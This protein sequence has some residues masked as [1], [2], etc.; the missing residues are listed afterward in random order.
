MLVVGITGGVATGKSL[1]AGEFARLGA[2]VVDADALA[3][4]VLEPDLPAWREVVAEFGRHILAPDG[5]IDR[6]K[7]G[8]IVFA[9]PEK[10]SRLEQ[11][12]HPRVLAEQVRRLAELKIQ[13]AQPLVVLDVP[14]LIEVGWHKLVDRVALVMADYQCQVKRLQR[15][16]GLSEERAKLRI[17]A[18]LPLLEKQKHAHYIIYNNGSVEEALSQAKSVYNQLAPCGRG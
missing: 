8:D 15:R 5:T 16:N 10:R 4:K 3:R 2:R 18:Q 1:V 13:G 14:L 17:E 7:L 6:A 11:I 9:D 12:I